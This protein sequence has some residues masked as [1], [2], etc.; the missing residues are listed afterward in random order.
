M[1]W[2]L[3]MKYIYGMVGMAFQLGPPTLN[4]RCHSMLAAREV[5]L[6]LLVCGVPRS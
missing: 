6:S 2:L 1:T 3:G 4:D 5:L